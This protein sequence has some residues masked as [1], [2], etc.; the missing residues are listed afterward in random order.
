MPQR[1]FRLD[2][3][4]HLA[5]QLEIVLGRLRQRRR[6]RRLVCVRGRG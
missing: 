4:F 5:I 3:I 1:L 2:Q 6:W